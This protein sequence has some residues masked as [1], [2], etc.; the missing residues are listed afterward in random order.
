MIIK[1]INLD[2]GKIIDKKVQ[3]N[4]FPSLSFAGDLAASATG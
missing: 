4:K 2:G 3:A 1:Q